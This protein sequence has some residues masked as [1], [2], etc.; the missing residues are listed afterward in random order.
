MEP[1]HP[2][3]LEVYSEEWFPCSWK[4]TNTGGLPFPKTKLRRVRTAH[5]EYEPVP[6]SR[7][8]CDPRRP[9]TDTDP[10][11]TADW[12]ADCPTTPISDCC[13]KNNDVERGLAL[14]WCGTDT[15]PAR[16]LAWKPGTIFCRRKEGGLF[17]FSCFVSFFSS[18]RY[19]PQ[20]SR[21][22]I[23]YIYIYVCVRS[24]TCSTVF[25]RYLVDL[26]LL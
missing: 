16:R 7:Q 11:S 23:I 10:H 1:C 9:D 4:V 5:Q 6:G 8:F 19:L 22:C 12:L 20:R 26:L 24:V 25:A 21:I 14:Y 18:M 3:R 17:F 15:P 2:S 13:A